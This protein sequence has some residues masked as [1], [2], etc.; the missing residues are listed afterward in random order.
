MVKKVFGVVGDKLDSL[1]KFFDELR[2]PQQESFDKVVEKMIEK[3]LP[4]LFDDFMRGNFKANALIQS[5]AERKVSEE[6]AKQVYG[7]QN[8]KTMKEM[9]ALKSRLNALMRSKK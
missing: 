5:A 8:R 4:D 1:S 2:T 6:V 7:N 3:G 9:G